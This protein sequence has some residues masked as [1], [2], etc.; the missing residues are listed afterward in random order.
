[1]RREP[2]EVVVVENGLRGAEAGLV[3][4][5][6]LTQLSP[7][8]AGDLRIKSSHWGQLRIDPQRS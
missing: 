4:G 8:S 7:G 5:C 1:S 3:C 6:T 2:V